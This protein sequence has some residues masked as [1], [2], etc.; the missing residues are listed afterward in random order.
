MLITDLAASHIGLGTRDHLFA[1]AEGCAYTMP[2]GPLQSRQLNQLLGLPHGTI[3]GVHVGV[4]T[5]APFIKCM[6][7]VYRVYSAACMTHPM[8]IWV[9]AT[10]TILTRGEDRPIQGVLVDHRTYF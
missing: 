4:T 2:L 3:Q 7:M 9:D 10:I 1:H 5:T 8:M 6:D